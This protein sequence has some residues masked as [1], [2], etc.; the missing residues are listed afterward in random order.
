MLPSDLRCFL[1]FH[2]CRSRISW[3]RGNDCCRRCTKPKVR[4]RGALVPPVL[5]SGGLT[6]MRWWPPRAAVDAHLS[7]ASNGPTPEINP[8]MTRWETR[9]MCRDCAGSAAR[10][11]CSQHLRVAG[12][13]GGVQL[14]APCT[15][16]LLSG[17]RDWKSGSSEC[18]AVVPPRCH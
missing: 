7:T 12:H 3:L 16:M 10:L 1:W 14:R 17:T 8:R 5:P 9:Q 11:D 2:E 6:R 18:C 13:S 4:P 15:Y